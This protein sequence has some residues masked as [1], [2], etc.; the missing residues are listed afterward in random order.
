MMSFNGS[1]SEYDDDNSDKVVWDLQLKEKALQE[2]FPLYERKQTEPKRM[3]QFQPPV[4]CTSDK[5]DTKVKYEI[6]LEDNIRGI[7]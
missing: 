4:R 5:F 1:E 7:Q 3:L 2:G 6:R